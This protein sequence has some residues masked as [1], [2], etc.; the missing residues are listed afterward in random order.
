ML[1]IIQLNHLLTNTSNAEKATLIQQE[2]VPLYHELAVERMNK[3]A[4]KNLK[5][6]KKLKKA[7]D[8]KVKEKKKEHDKGSRHGVKSKKHNSRPSVALSE[9]HVLDIEI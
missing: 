7:N 2:N 4:N 9:F 1:E 6:V 8:L 5:Q 3:K